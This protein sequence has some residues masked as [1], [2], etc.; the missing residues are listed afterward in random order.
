M[1][2][3]D[4][5]KRTF[6][7]KELRRI[8]E[9]EKTIKGAIPNELKDIYKKINSLDDI[10]Y[11]IGSKLQ[12]VIDIIPGLG[13]QGMLASRRDVR[14]A[15]EAAEDARRAQMSEW[16]KQ[17]AGLTDAYTSANAELKSDMQS[18]MDAQADLWEKQSKETQ[19]RMVAQR[20]A[21]MRERRA[22]GDKSMQSALALSNAGGES[23]RLGGTAT[24]SARITGRRSRGIRATGAA[25][26]NIYGRPA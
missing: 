10:K 12:K 21:G 19:N 3:F 16:D 26:P 22:L 8:N 13:G 18:M 2:S 11:Q 25:I 20:V 14:K 24:T 23:G 17:M 6:I 5:F 1:N 9:L 4:D 15:E 7:P